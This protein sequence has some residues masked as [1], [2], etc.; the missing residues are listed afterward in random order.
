MKPG[1]RNAV[2][3]LKDFVFPVAAGGIISVNK[4]AVE[5]G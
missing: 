4:L 2:R 1:Q 5:F 3:W